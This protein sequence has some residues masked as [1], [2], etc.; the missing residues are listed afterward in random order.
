MMMRTIR[1]LAALAFA[2]VLPA[3]VLAQESMTFE[4]AWEMVLSHHP[5]IQAVE[6]DIQA[7]QADLEQSGRG[8]NPELEFE[9]ENFVGSGYYHGFD[10]ADLT[11]ALAQTWELGGKAGNRRA[12]AQARV[13]ISQ[14]A[15]G[16]T[17][18]NLRRD[19]AAAFVNV[20]AAQRRVALADS[21]DIV[22]E[23]DRREVERRID[24]GAGNR[25][26]GQMALL[27][28]AAAHNQMQDTHKELVAAR[29]VL[30]TLWGDDLAAF[31][32]IVGR[33]EDLVPVP[34]WAEI[35]GRVDSSPSAALAAAEVA[36]SRAGIEL[37]NSEGAI[38]LTTALGV[39]HFRGDNDNAMVVSV[40]LPIPVRNANKD[41][42][43]AAAADLGVSEAM[44]RVAAIELKGQ[45]AA[46]W[47][48]MDITRSDVAAIRSQILPAATLA[49]QEADRAYRQGRFSVTEVLMVRRTWTE[50]QL[51]LVDV[52]AR[53]HLAAIQLNALVGDDPAKEVLR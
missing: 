4:S 28:A 36:R 33:F 46:A 34:D 16:Q 9:V 32:P 35:L 29:M 38:D 7:R 30:G 5:A 27:A 26:E 49:M 51:K 10:S 25:V 3:V 48:E 6:A 43:R 20:L 37:A 45:L 24:A 40:A 1:N 8:L 31:P 2:L 44:A 14:A 22:A 42:Q 12:V 21:L 23:A 41:A 39:R 13:E 47:N 15:A 17:R 11:L 53:H 19:F 18:R 50:W 52:L